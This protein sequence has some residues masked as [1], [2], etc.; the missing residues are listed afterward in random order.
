MYAYKVK[1]KFFTKI[2]SLSVSTTVARICISQVQLLL[3]KRFRPS[4]KQY[5]ILT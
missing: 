3:L 2:F 1:Q 4:F 5:D